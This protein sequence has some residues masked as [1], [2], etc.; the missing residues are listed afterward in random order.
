[1]SPIAITAPSSKFHCFKN[2][3]DRNKFDNILDA[4]ILETDKAGLN[5]ADCF[6][7]LVQFYVGDNRV[8][9]M[10]WCN[11]KDGLWKWPLYISR[12]MLVQIAKPGST[13]DNFTVVFE[14]KF[15]WHLVG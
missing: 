10:S 1:M 4:I 12:F 3:C 13:L 14:D 2:V 15:C 8:G 7:R 11:S 5:R 9:Q 6:E